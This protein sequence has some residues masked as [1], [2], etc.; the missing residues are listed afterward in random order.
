MNSLLEV[1]DLSY[2]YGNSQP[3]FDK[4]AFK[5]QRGQL[6]TILGP[7]GAGKSTLLN[8]I[9]G[10]L[11]PRSGE[12]LLDGRPVHSLSPRELARKTAYVPQS[13]A[14]VYD[15]TV[16]DYISMGRAAHLGMFFQPGAE[17]YRIVDDAIDMIKIRRF[18]HKSCAGI[19]GGERQMAS[20]ARAIVQQ[21]E[22]IIFDEPTSALDYGNQMKVMQVV[23]NLAKQGY[24][25]IMTTHN[26]DQPILLGGWV[27]LVS[28]AGEF[29]MGRVEDIM[30]EDILSEM[31]N[32][33]LSITYVEEVERMAC[34][35]K[36][37]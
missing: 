33:S 12:V 11:K 1:R 29:I 27:A 10:L 31:Y 32:T 13:S 23:D 16:R 3:V 35:V 17:D 19:S 36:K 21:T 20:I 8:C 30:K 37:L 6:L 5:L 2:S 9:A 4:V 24:A 34:I 7:N 15:Y 26:P 14:T 18:A 25:I 22:L 28:A